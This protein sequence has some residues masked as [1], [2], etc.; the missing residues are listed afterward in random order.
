[1]LWHEKVQGV[2]KVGGVAN[3]S[4]GYA[5]TS[6]NQYP[7]ATLGLARQTPRLMQIRYL[8]PHLPTSNQHH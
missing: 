2:I 7:L 1:M 5:K 4:S 6:H 8:K 3:I